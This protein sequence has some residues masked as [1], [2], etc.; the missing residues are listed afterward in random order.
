MFDGGARDPDINAYE[1][2]GPDLDRADSR[3]RLQGWM[4]E[5]AASRIGVTKLTDR[6]S[7]VRHGH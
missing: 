3:A 4:D 7:S 5:C 2:A 6:R 1:P